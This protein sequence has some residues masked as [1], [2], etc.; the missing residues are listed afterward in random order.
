MS[1]FQKFDSSSSNDLKVQNLEDPIEGIS[2]PG[3]LDF[4]Y[5]LVLLDIFNC[6]NFE[7][8][9]FSGL[10]VASAEENKTKKTFLSAI[11][12]HQLSRDLALNL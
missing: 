4:Y 3:T 10:K 9:A 8:S 7:Y 6:S 12:M 11:S 1:P 5:T 2:Q